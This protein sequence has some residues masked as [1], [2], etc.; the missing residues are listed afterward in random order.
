MSSKDDFAE[1]FRRIEK[2]LLES[3]S[4]PC[5]DLHTGDTFCRIWNKSCADNLVKGPVNHITGQPLNVQAASVKKGSRSKSPSGKRSLPPT[6]EADE[7]PSPKKAKPNNSTP[8]SIPASIPVAASSSTQQV[9]GILAGTFGEKYM[10]RDEYP[11]PEAVKDVVRFRSKPQRND[12]PATAC[13]AL[14]SATMRSL[15][16]EM[17]W[18]LPDN[19]KAIRDHV[20]Q[21]EGSCRNRKD[22]QAEGAYCTCS[23]GFLETPSPAI[24]WKALSEEDCRKIFELCGCRPPVALKDLRKWEESKQELNKTDT[25]KAV[26]QT[27]CEFSSRAIKACNTVNVIAA[28]CSPSSFLENM[29]LVS[30]KSIISKLLESAEAVPYLQQKGGIREF[31]KEYAEVMSK[32]HKNGPG[33][34]TEL[35]PTYQVLAAARGL[36]PLTLVSELTSRRSSAGSSA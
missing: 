17:H 14:S 36:L 30:K 28:L 8:A 33:I 18:K 23:R 34:Y 9:E 7:S 22:C 26:I 12:L 16:S 15:W 4:T 35:L 11:S 1:R 10:M 27:I 29:L 19:L 3:P 20:F 24:L 31:S 2:Q 32:S 21:R 25:G 13:Y 5:V 6:F